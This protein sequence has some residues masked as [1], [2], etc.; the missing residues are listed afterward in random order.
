MTLLRD[1]P[2]DF[3]ALIGSAAHDTGLDTA[4]IEKDYWVTE[5]L[6]SL[7]KPISIQPEAP[8]LDV[9]VFKGGTSLS[10]AYGLIERFSEDVDILVVPPQDAGTGVIDRLLKTLV[11]RA[12]EDLGIEE[13]LQTSTR[14]V[15]RNVTYDYPAL[16]RSTALNPTLLL[17]MGIRGGAT[18]SRTVS[19]ESYVGQLAGR[20][21]ADLEAEDLAPVSTRVLSPER[22]L[23]E[24]LQLVH[25]AAS[26]AGQNPE[27]ILRIG[28]HL[29]DIYQ[30]IDS[31]DV[32]A[33][34][35]E[36]EGGVPELAAEIHRRSLNAGYSSVPRPDSG[37]AASAAIT[38]PKLRP[39]LKE[40]YSEIEPLL[41]GQLPDFGVVIETIKEN[42]A[43]L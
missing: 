10:K 31:D 21:A 15:K 27:G 9:V 17:E 12:S 5:L 26:L 20:L 18:P 43:Q 14:G 24:K 37:Y 1:S 22:T 11:A 25:T 40:A 3:G 32:M 19:I 30:L 41:W 16:H 36:V 33:A 7:T 23:V 29:Y 4:F 2:A 35:S 8:L 34:L 42:A 13:R 38:E 39:V 6:R 28:R